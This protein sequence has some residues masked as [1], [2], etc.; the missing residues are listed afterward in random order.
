MRVFKIPQS[1]ANPLSVISNPKFV[2]AGSYFELGIIVLAKIRLL[3][4]G[5]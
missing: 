3:L 2:F 1:L 4:L 5:S